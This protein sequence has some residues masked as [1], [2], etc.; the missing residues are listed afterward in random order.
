MNGFILTLPEGVT[1]WDRGE[2]GSWT[3]IG[4]RRVEE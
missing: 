2:E 3:L 1:P 4:K